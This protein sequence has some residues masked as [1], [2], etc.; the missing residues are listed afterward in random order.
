MMRMQVGMGKWGERRKERGRGGEG[1][2]EID[3]GQDEM[4][5]MVVAPQLPWLLLRWFV[6]SDVFHIPRATN[7]E[8]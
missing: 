5:M 3:K 7:P 8:Y 4:G 6:D 1:K 2:R